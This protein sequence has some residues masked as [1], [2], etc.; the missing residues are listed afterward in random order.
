M[1]DDVTDTWL[2]GVVAHDDALS[3]VRIH[4]GYVAYGPT[5]GRSWRVQVRLRY[6]DPKARAFPDA[7]TAAALIACEEHLVDRFGDDAVLVAVLTV[8]GFR[9]LIFHTATPEACGVTVGGDVFGPI[10]DADVDVEFAVDID[11][12]EDPAWSLYRSLFGDAV[13]ADAD[14]RRVEDASLG[15]RDAEHGSTVEHRFSFPSLA[16]A[17]QAAA[18]L[19]DAGLD[20]VY[21]AAVDDGGSAPAR[22]AVTDT[23][24]LDQVAMARSRD[25]LSGFANS[26][27][28]E[29]L[30]WTVV[31]T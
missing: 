12:A 7:D 25:T 30:G 15:C 24:V 5:S 9:D 22:F 8:P 1:P 14:R 13:T 20:A 19:R 23:E 6:G 18:A 2:V 3:G 27:G 10:D 21:D 28:G 17:D 29:Y 4:A 11:V 16:E 26:W 31:D